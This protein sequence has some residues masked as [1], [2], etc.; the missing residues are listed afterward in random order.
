MT[1]RIPRPHDLVGVW[2]LNAWQTQQA[3]GTIGQPFGEDA[4]GLLFYS[5]SGHVSGQMMRA[6]R[7]AF[8][9]P[10]FQAVEFDTG[11][12]SELATAFNS[13]LAYAGTWTI[14]EDALVRHHVEVASIPGWAG[15]T[16]LREARFT[17]TRLTLLT[18]PRVIGGIEQRGI[19]HWERA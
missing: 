5:D 19:L 16:L 12:P 2:R 3:D 11:D 9:Q 13:F 4:V 8:S 7:P 1:D 17:G 18:L 14:G 15:L 10:R 6:N